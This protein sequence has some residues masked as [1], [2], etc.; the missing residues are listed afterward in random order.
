[1]TDSIQVHRVSWVRGLSG[2]LLAPVVATA[3]AVGVLAGWSDDLPDPVAVHFGPGGDADGFAARAAALWSPL[4][5]LAFAVILGGILLLLTRRDVRAARMGA[6]TASGVG[7]AVA[8]LPAGLLA[9]QRGLDDAT[10]A[11]FGGWWLAVA[12]LVGV[13]AAFVGTVLVGR[14][15]SA[16]AAAVPP[17]DASRLDLADTEKVVWTGA[18]TMP[19]WLAVVLALV[20]LVIVVSVVWATSE[21]A[22]PMLL[23]AA[24]VG[25]LLM[26]LAL[27][28]VHVVV[29]DRGLEARY[30]L[31][32][33]RR[34][35]PLDEIARADTVHIGLI[36]RYGGIGYRVGPDGVGLLVRPG[37]ALRVTRGDGSKFTVT[38]DGADQ[39]AA[40]LNS[41]AARG[42]VAR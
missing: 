36:N 37:E 39:A 33:G 7:A 25:A 6:A 15:P 16:S 38:V 4:L 10:T 21:S 22:V 23:V 29:D 3:T 31:T 2:A 34:R 1:M 12:A 19:R 40:V 5:G 11:S 13:V 26:G 14:P 28:P 41:L 35:I 20:P 27:A 42:R 18:A 24:I 17:A 9:G 8:I 30:V 32:G